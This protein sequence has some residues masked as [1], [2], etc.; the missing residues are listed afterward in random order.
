M[1]ANSGGPRKSELQLDARAFM[2]SR[3][4]NF[5]NQPLSPAPF[6]LSKNFPTPTTARPTVPLPISW[7]SSLAE[8]R[9]VKK[10]PSNFYTN[11]SALIRAPTP[12]AAR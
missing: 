11:A 4:L 12:L 10:R 9:T 5:T 6:S 7:M 2:D 3:L 8:T 1:A